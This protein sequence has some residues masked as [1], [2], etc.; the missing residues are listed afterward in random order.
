M[1]PDLDPARAARDARD[2]R[3]D[4]RPRRPMRDSRARRAVRRRGAGARARAS[5]HGS[6]SKPT[7]QRACAPRAEG[8]ARVRAARPRA[9]AARGDARAT[10]SASAS[11]AT[12]MRASSGCRRRRLPNSWSRISNAPARCAART[13]TCCRCDGGVRAKAH[14]GVRATGAGLPARRDAARCSDPESRFLL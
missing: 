6:A 3:D 13:G 11:I 2:A 12:S 1:P 9:I 14:I 7:R 8:G 10:S 5:A 4:R